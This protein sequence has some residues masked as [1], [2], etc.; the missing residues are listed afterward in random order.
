[1]TLTT[2]QQKLALWMWGSGKNTYDIARSL[3]DNGGSKV[4]RADVWDF[5]T[6][7]VCSKAMKNP[8]V[9]KESA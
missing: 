4:R 5:I 7:H 1:M 8:Q 2:G 3:T 9:Q 6:A